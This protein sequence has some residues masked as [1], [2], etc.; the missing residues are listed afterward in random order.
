MKEST[1]RPAVFGELNVVGFSESLQNIKATNKKAENAKNPK[2]GILCFFH[3]H[4]S[5]KEL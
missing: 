2:N 4:L 3:Y 1:S 5:Q